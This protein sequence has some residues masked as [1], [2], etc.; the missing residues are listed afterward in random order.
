MAQPDDPGV[1]RSELADSYEHQGVG[2]G[3]LVFMLI[4]LA[5]LVLAIIFFV[6]AAVPCAW[7]LEPGAGIVRNMAIAEGVSPDFA[8]AIGH[9]ESGLRCEVPHSSAGA[10]GIMQVMPRTAAAMGVSR[11]ELATCEGSARAGVRYLKAALKRTG[12]DEELAAHLYLAGLGAR[13]QRSP[14]ARSVMVH[15]RRLP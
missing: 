14:Y 1:L 10:V 4:C 2:L 11:A 9:Q 12:G 5:T 3:S 13:P 6:A 15:K 8:L 7:A